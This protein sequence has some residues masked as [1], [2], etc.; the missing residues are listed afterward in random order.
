MV[1]LHKAKVQY[2]QFVDSSAAVEGEAPVREV[3]ADC[4]AVAS[5]S[6]GGGA[7]AGSPAILP[8]P[9]ARGARLAVRRRATYVSPDRPAPAGSPGKVHS[10]KSPV[11]SGGAGSSGTYTMV[12]SSASSATTASTTD[13][14]VHQAVETPA[15]HT[16]QRQLPVNLAPVPPIRRRASDGALSRHMRR[17]IATQADASP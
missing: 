5:R 16:R 7:P 14:V 15:T 12:A 10:K 17:Q 11:L 6:G 4:G 1:Q 2:K 13:V 9:P 8:S 3:V